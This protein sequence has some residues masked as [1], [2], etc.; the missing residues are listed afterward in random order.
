MRTVID[1]LD[2]VAEPL[3]EHYEARGGKFHLK[4]EDQPSGYV[5]A[6]DL[7]AANAK[8]V[9]FRDNNIRLIK[10][11][12]EA[13]AL[14]T[15]FEGL[16]PEEARQ[17]IAKSKELGKKGVQ[18]ADELDARLKTM[19]DEAVKPLR[20]QIAES[21]AATKAERDRADEFLLKSMI[22]EA[23]TKAGGKPNAT[24][25]IVNLAKEHF[26][27]RDSNVVAKTGKFSTE[28]PG[29]SLT[30]KEWLESTVLKEHDYV[31]QPSNGGGAP[32]VKGA[33]SPAIRAKAG[34]TILLN[35][36]PQELGAN[37]AGIKAGTVKIS[38]E[39]K[40]TH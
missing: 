31:F 29:E 19:V 24:D 28:K 11:A 15:K 5:K 25:F 4:I 22:G 30:T 39:D 40:S 13:R 27:V 37:A 38:F 2:T 35:P 7:L 20:Q 1:A 8:V 6:E 33:V 23:F 17:A 36:T 12:D 9:E 3:R 21:Q 34:Q 14:R 10:E 16:D 26:E 18:N 32:V